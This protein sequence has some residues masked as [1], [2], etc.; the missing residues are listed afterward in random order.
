MSMDIPEP[1]DGEGVGSQADADAI[2]LAGMELGEKQHEKDLLEKR[3]LQVRDFAATQDVVLDP[4]IAEADSIDALQ[5]LGR[6]N[7]ESVVAVQVAALITIGSGLRR[8]D[9][10]TASVSDPVHL[11]EETNQ[12]R[13][14]TFG[15]LA[16]FVFAAEPETEDPDAW[17][18]IQAATLGIPAEVRA[19]LASGLSEAEIIKQA[20]QRAVLMNQLH[21]R[22]QARQAPIEAELRAQL[23]AVHGV[24]EDAVDMLASEVFRASATFIVLPNRRGDIFAKLIP[25]IHSFA[26]HVTPET[27]QALVNETAKKIITKD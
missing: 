6:Q 27:V 12:V 17:M 15:D 18:K 23:S 3:V 5:E 21:E 22:T 2:A 7:E 19:A 13:T 25:T 26:P 10:I 14:Q 9:Q 1:V 11:E 20:R 8:M 4:R 16:T 24:D